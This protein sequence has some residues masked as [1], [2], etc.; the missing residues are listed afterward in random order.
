MSATI[1]SLVYLE[2]M[3]FRRSIELEPDAEPNMK[4]SMAERRRM[5]HQLIA[6][7]SIRPNESLFDRILDR[8]LPRLPK[9]HPYTKF[10]F[11]I[12]LALS[13]GNASEFPISSQAVIRTFCQEEEG[14]TRIGLRTDNIRDHIDAGRLSLVYTSLDQ[15]IKQAFPYKNPE[16]FA[17]DL[18]VPYRTDE[19]SP[20]DKTLGDRLTLVRGFVTMDQFEQGIGEI[21]DDLTI[22]KDTCDSSSHNPLELEGND[23]EN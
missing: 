23:S 22:S 16:W 14:Q 13:A 5:L 6:K 15:S 20:F 19:T 2:N 10:T 18:D 17:L 21:M 11:A 1:K 4:L 7:G 8:F 9:I 3:F 12:A